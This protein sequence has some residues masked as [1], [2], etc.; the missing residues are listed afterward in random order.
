MTRLHLDYET[1]SAVDLLEAGLHT[2][3]RDKTTRVLMAA[4]ESNL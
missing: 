3:A 2:Y 4:W 1:R